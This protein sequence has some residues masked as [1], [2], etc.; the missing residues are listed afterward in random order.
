M[1]RVADCTNRRGSACCIG[2]RSAC[3]SLDEDDL[4]VKLRAYLDCRS[5]HVEPPPPLVEAW[6]RFYDLYRPR[7]RAYLARFRLS[8]ADQED[9]LQDVWSKVLSRPSTLP[10][11]PPRARLSAWLMTVARNRAVDVIRHRRRF[12]V[13]WNEDA[14]AVVDTEPGPAAAYERSS[15]QRRVRRVLGELCKQATAL[16]F[17]VFYL[18]TI[19]GRT[20]TEVANTLGL[21]PDQVRFRLHR[22]RC[23]FRDLLQH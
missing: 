8:Q 2:Q 21:T 9:C 22:M 1:T 16:S 11:G 7:V 19:D 5:H 14:F 6:D 13:Q 12:S 15:T 20:G 18:R 10:D 23:K 4:C 3:P 17:Q